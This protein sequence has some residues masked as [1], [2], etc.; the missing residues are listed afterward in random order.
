MYVWIDGRVVHEH[1]ARVSPLDHGITVGDGVFETLR[2]HDGAPFAWTRHVERMQRSAAGLGI[3]A[4]D[5]DALRRGAAAVL[6]ANELRDARLRLTVTSG[7]GPPGSG[8]G[9]GPPL[10]LA[11]AVPLG[12]IEPV[13]DV[14]TVPWTRNEHSALAGLKTTSYGENVRALAVA[15]ERGAHEA[16]FANT[17]G[18]LCEGTGTNVFVVQDGVVRTPPLSSGC[19]AGITRALVAELCVLH[20]VPVEEV[21]LPMDALTASDEVFLTSSVR[22]VVA[23]GTVDGQSIGDGSGVLTRRLADAYRALVTSTPDP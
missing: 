4:P 19:L 14:V 15:T 22:E 11:V 2:V 13:V 12:T 7:V 16:L 21:D 20:D 1:D 3:A 6:E 9:D 10:Q 17:R 5:G 18:R 23:V 8:R